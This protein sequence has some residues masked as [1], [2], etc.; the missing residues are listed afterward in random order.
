MNL[1]AFKHR[2]RLI[3][4]FILVMMVV[5]FA[6]KAIIPAGFMPEAKGGFMEMVI[7]SGMGERTVL[8][9]NSDTLPSEHHNDTF[10]KEVCAY[11]VLASGK[12]LVS[13]PAV[14]FHEPQ[15]EKLSTNITDDSFIVSKHQ[16][17]F[18][19]RGPPS[20]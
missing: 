12:V 11:Q 20:A 10:D 1:C 7:C 16:L 9:P 14:V 5:A 3:F 8:V 13:A 19:A 6:L 2:R 17:S 18:E 15:P 4:S